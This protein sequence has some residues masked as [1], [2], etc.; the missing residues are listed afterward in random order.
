MLFYLELPMGCGDAPEVQLYDPDGSANGAR[1]ESGFVALPGN[2]FLL[3][4][5]MPSSMWRGAMQLYCGDDSEPCA[6]MALEPS[7]YGGAWPMPSPGGSVDVEYVVMSPVAHCPLQG[8]RVQVTTDVIGAVV[9]WS[10]ISDS[11]GV[12][13]DVDGGLLAVPLGTWYLWLDRVGYAF[14]NPYTLEVEA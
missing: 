14:D 1:I 6:G 12:A 10:G 7:E 3:D 11:E 5:E 13:R 2:A 9:I 4:I 8:V